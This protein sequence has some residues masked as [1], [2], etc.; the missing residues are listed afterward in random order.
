M[1]KLRPRAGE[2]PAFRALTPPLMTLEELY[3]AFVLLGRRT[4]FERSEIP[5]LAG[6]RIHFA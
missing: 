1:A 4:R 5:S 3:G 6:L 2:T